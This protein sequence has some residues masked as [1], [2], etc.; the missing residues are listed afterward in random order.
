MVLTIYTAKG[1]SINL[2]LMITFIA[3]QQVKIGLVYAA[4]KS[5]SPHPDNKYDAIIDNEN[6]PSH[7]KACKVSL[8]KRPSNTSQRECGS[9]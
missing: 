3:S 5:Y 6:A 1:L 8:P 4:V 2:A 7:I 9:T